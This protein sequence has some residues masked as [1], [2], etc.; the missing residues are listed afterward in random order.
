MA[1]LTPLGAMTCSVART[2]DVVGEWWTILIVRDA[3]LGVTRFEDFHRRLGV[4]R[5]VLTARLE[6]LVE[7]EVM[8]RQLY[9]DRPPRHEYVLTEKG[10]DL[11]PV[12]MAM[13][14][15]G[16]RWA[17][18]TDGPPLTLRHACGQ[19]LTAAPLCTGC[20]EPID[21]DHVSAEA[22]LPEAHGPMTPAGRGL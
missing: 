14:R 10:R 11:W 13:M 1:K 19:D 3:L 12:V 9:C 4:A 15:W 21:P 7:A 22:N 2:L 17:A 6:R 20:G 8:S 5:T 18:G 16:D